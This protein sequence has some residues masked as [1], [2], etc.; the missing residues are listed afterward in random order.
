M[1]VRVLAVDEPSHLPTKP[2]AM[3]FLPHE[4][5]VGRLEVWLL[6]YFSASTFNTTRNPLPV[7][8]GKPHHIH[9][10]PNATPYACHTPASKPKHWKDE[11][12]PRLE[13]DIRRGV[14]EPVPAR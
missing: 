10:E 6:Q 8:K 1:A 11:V 13:E 4:E 12:K 2:M 7:M 14:T 3:P 9:P 5:H